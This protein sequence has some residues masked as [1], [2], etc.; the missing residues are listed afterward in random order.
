M[1]IVAHAAIISSEQNTKLTQQHH[2]GTCFPSLQADLMAASGMLGNHWEATAG[3]E[4]A[5]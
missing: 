3:A 2:D 4:V 5:G 1:H